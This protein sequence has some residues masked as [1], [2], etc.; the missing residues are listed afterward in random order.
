V[1]P[2]VPRTVRAQ[3]AIII[4]RWRETK[5]KIVNSREDP[6]LNYREPRKRQFG[7][8]GHRVFPGQESGI[9]VQQ[10]RGEISQEIGESNLDVS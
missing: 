7:R 6:H 10:R 2:I 9:R 8:M 3:K 5:D 1:A 4:R